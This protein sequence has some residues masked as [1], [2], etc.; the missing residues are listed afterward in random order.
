MV[1]IPKELKHFRKAE[2]ATNKIKITIND[3]A[4]FKQAS[5]LSPASAPESAEPLFLPT[6]KSVVNQAL[7][8]NR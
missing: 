3:C 2:A 6:V 8:R 5:T 1:L 4:R 7:Q